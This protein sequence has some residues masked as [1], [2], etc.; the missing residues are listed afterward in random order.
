MLFVLFYKE[1]KMEKQDWS[2][3]SNGEWYNKEDFLFT[4]D[5]EE[6]QKN[7]INKNNAWLILTPKFIPMYPELLQKW[8]TITESCLYWFID[9]FLS[10]NGKFYCTNEQLAKMLNVSEPVISNW[11]KKLKEQWYIEVWYKIKAWGWQIRF[12]K[13]KSPTLKNFKSDI[14]KVN[15]IY[16]KVIENK[17]KDYL[18]IN[19]S[20]AE[21]LEESTLLNICEDEEKE[22]SS[23]KKEKE[24]YGREDINNLIESIKNKCNELWVMYDKTKEREFS[25]HIL[26]AK[27]FWENAEKCGMSREI[28][29]I[30]ILVASIKIKYWKWYCNW[31]MK[32]YQNYVDVYNQTVKEKSKNIPIVAH[33]S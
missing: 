9:F 30:N 27:E 24:S 3:M 17:K 23:A 26:T 22:K 6:K 31:P 33:I 15:G 1:N 12:I 19:N 16:N 18:Y 14:K 32:I 13:N 20:E 29:A 7:E 21:I 5:E 2:I 4:Y 11:I 28:F 25:K 8:F 10:N